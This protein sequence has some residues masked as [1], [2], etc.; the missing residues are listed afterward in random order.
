MA[1]RDAA[2]RART[3]RES[4]HE[5]NHRYFVLDAP[6]ISDSEYD[7]L[8]RELTQIEAEH[9]ELITPDSPTQRVGA[10]PLAAFDTVRHRVP[11]MSLANAF[12]EDELRAFDQRVRRALEGETVEYVTEL[13][14]DG[15]A[16]NLT[17]ENGLLVRGATRGDGVEGED[18]TQ[19]LR[20]VE[21]IPLRLSRPLSFDVRGE[22]FMS[23][24]GFQALNER[25]DAEGSPL[26]A[27]PRNASAGSLRQLDPKIT[28]ERPLDAFFYQIGTIDEATMNQAVPTTHWDVLSFLRDIGLKVNPNAAHCPDIEQV[29]EYCRKWAAERPEL[30]Y[31]IDGVVVKVNSLASHARLGATAK[32]P[33]W[34]TAYKFPA[35]QAVTVVE[36]IDVN[37]GRTGAVTPMAFLRPVRVAGTTVSRATLHNEDFIRQKDIRIGDTVVIQKA[38]DIIP[39]VVR[40]DTSKRSGNER[41]FTMPTECPDCG[42]RVV[43]PEGEAVARC[44][45]SECPAQLVEGLVHFASRA[46]MDIEGLGPAVASALVENG[47]VQ[48]VSDLYRLTLDQIAGLERMGEKSASN[49]LAALNASKERGLARVLYALG[50]RHVGSGTASVIAE[51]FLSM[52]AVL[53]ADASQLEAVPDVGPKVAESV[54][55]YLREPKNQRLVSQLK[56]AGVRMIEEAPADVESKPLE[57]KR[58][59]LTGTLAGMSRSEAEEKIRALGGLTS[60]SVSRKTDYVV[61][62]ESPG[63]K[64]E[65]ARELGVSILDEAELRALLEAKD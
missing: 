8:M 27:N 58:F 23:K 16:V 36:N 46:A 7:A 3:L 41:V 4:L 51:H 39:E 48:N 57:G 54:V 21:S 34:A 17:Y 18:V 12:D 35:E 45:N 24:S 20:T 63:S 60:G 10:A 14:I 52:D 2:E 33:R 28:A 11:M 43:R 65:K 59:V 50:V 5:H 53:A 13:K 62:G 19:N 64:A 6:L 56:E 37:V 29:I 49:L 31:E 26:F 55:Q 1:T 32:T 9:P 22:V 25:R 40:V 42:G 61:V 30:P 38:G 15:V 44:V 47:F